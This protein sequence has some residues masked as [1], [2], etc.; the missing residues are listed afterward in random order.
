[1]GVGEGDVAL[2]A[3]MAL[4]YRT[5]MGPAEAL[6]IALGGGPDAAAFPPEL[7]EREAEDLEALRA[8][9]VRL[10]TIAD[11]EYPARLR[12][13]P[14]PLLLQVAGRAALLGD[15]AVEVLAGHKR[16]PG[17]L[18]AGHRAVVVLS[19]G[20]LRAR[21]LLRAL[22]EPVEDGAVALVSAEP[23]RATWGPVRDR[24]RDALVQALKP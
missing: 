10:L 7:L 20:M 5:A 23:P 3:W 12:E 16:L 11:P 18:D 6:A 24:R 2:A 8:L 19:K 17:V 14:A 9:G 4:A 1:M 21:T 15:E 22:A 13:G